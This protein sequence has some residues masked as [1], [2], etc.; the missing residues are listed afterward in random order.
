ML[1]RHTSN[2]AC[3]ARHTRARSASA[4]L[5]RPETNR[6]SLGGRPTR[7]W[8]AMGPPGL[9]PTPIRARPLRVQESANV[10]SSTGKHG[11]SPVGESAARTVFPVRASERRVHVR[12]SMVRKGSPV[13]VRQRASPLQGF[14]QPP[15]VGS[16][17][18]GTPEEHRPPR[19]RDKG[20]A[21][22]RHAHEALAVA[23]K[24][25]AQGCG[26]ARPAER[27]VAW[28]G[29]VSPSPLL[30]T[31]AGAT[32]PPIVRRQRRP[33]GER[34]NSPRRWRPISGA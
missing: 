16:D 4:W 14:S 18:R 7:R 28:I 22:R 24:A 31:D 10:R 25:A 27:R 15:V 2:A 19:P 17:D 13:R 34:G 9:G 12:G 6:D 8:S 33:P 32:R 20:S 3:P 1:K 29:A 26:T 30:L 5:Q 23:T 21:G 11:T